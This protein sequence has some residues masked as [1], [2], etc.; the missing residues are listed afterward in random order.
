MKKRFSRRKRNVRRKSFRRKKFRMSKRTKITKY[1]GTVYSKCITVGDYTC[2]GANSYA[3]LVVSWG[4]NGVDT[5]YERFI[6]NNTEFTT[7]AGLYDQYKIVG[8]KVNLEIISQVTNAA[9]SGIYA[10]NRASDTNA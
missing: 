6:S 8:F 2:N 9:G 3:P 7:M 10:V 1:D 5:A 4:D